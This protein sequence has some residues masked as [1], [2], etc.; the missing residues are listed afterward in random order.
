MFIQIAILVLLTMLLYF[1]L[2]RFFARRVLSAQREGKLRQ[3]DYQRLL[4]EYDQLTGQNMDLR[5]RLEQ[6]MTLYDI[7]RE[8]CS[9]LDQDKVFSVFKEKLHKMLAVEDCRFVPADADLAA[10]KEYA[11]VPLRLEDQL[12]NYLVVAPVRREDRDKFTILSQQFLLGMKRAILY[13]KVQEM[14]TIDGLTQVSARR[15]WWGRSSEELSRSRAF[16]YA[17]ACLMLD[18]DHFKDINDHYGH[19]VGDAI[20]K[21]VAQRIKAHIRQVDLIGK[22]GGEEFA[23]LLTETNN[24]GALFVAERIRAGIQSKPVVAYDERIDVTVSV[25][26]SLFPQQGKELAGLLDNADK[27]LYQAKK[28]GRNKVELFTG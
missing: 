28:S 13:Q 14:A 17:C 25:G 7:T 1:R 18:V 5:N 10:F 8:L 11:I 15:Y 3:A 27:A 22:Y 19:L 4:Q 20:L 16:N 26:I 21:E 6:T 24:E 12:M 23:I 9:H 2:E